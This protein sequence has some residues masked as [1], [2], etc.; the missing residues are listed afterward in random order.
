MCVCVC[1][2]QFIDIV[3]AEHKASNLVRAKEPVKWL[4]KDLVN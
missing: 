2:W 1:V 4:E 3:V